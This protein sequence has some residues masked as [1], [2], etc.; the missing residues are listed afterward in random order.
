MRFLLT[1][2]VFFIEGTALFAADCGEARVLYDKGDFIGAE[3]NLFAIAG[4]LDLPCIKLLAESQ[5]AQGRLKEA[6][7]S[8]GRVAELSHQDKD[9]LRNLARLY[10]WTDRYSESAAAYDA[11]IALDPADF[12]AVVEKARVLGWDKK[13]TEASSA[14]TAAF[15]ASKQEWIEEER[16]GKESLWAHRPVTGLAHLKKAAELNDGD[17]EALSDLAQFYSATGEYDRAQWY[18][19]RLLKAAPYHTA[20][21]RSEEKNAVYQDGFKLSGSADLLDAHSP[22][23]KTGVW[24]QNFFVT[25]SK[26]LDRHFTVA[27]TGADALYSFKHVPLLDERGTGL[28]LSYNGGY[29]GGASASY[30]RKVFVQDIGSRENYSVSGWKKALENLNFS[31]SAVKENMIN[32][33][34][35]VRESRDVSYRK[36]RADWDAN[37]FLLA[38]ADW[39]GGEINDGNQ[40]KIYGADLRLTY[41]EEPEAFY[42]LLRYEKQHYKRHSG[43]YFAPNDYNT[44]SFTQVFKKNIGGE[45]LYYGA[46]DAYYEFS[47][48]VVYDESGYLLFRPSAALYK[49]LSNRLSLKAGWSLTVSHYYRDNCYFARAGWVF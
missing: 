15:E 4:T 41:D 7:V 3:K 11:V 35:N 12:S 36:L 48:S 19:D 25:V 1:A 14:Y 8:F 39:D 6:S 32:N 13:Y 38:G 28:S 42:S 31:A 22:G 49:D 16:L 37:D 20:A 26:R 30:T 21:L 47:G 9:S 29:S 44:Y 43:S 45:G 34:T 5:L 17:T 2:L 33:F 10:S 46:N 40:F 23:R 24:Y 27:G 18:Y